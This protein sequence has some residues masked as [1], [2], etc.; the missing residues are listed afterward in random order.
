MGVT[1]FAGESYENIPACGVQK[2]KAK[3]SQS[4]TPGLIKGAGKRAKS[5]AAAKKLTG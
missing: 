4:Q 3:Q 1:S 2:N 5:L